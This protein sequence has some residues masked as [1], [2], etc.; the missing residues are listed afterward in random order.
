MFRYGS[1]QSQAN[2]NPLSKPEHK[3]NRKSLLGICAAKCNKIMCAFV[4]LANTNLRESYKNLDLNL[5]M[6]SLFVFLKKCVQH[7]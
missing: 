4:F 5:Y 6:E 2:L 7:R 1:V 3:G